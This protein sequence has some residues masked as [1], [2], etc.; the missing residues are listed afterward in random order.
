MTWQVIYYL[1]PPGKNPVSKFID[2]CQKKQQ[3]KILRTLRY[4]KE[5]GPQTAIPH[6]KKLSGT[7]FWE[8]R[9]LGKDNI[10][11][12]YIT[13][14]EKTI[15]LLHGF[16]KKTRKTEQKELAICYQRYEEFKLTLDK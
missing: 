8:M 2:Y 4:L 1:S 15:I 13:S 9:I 5:Y 12:I 14:I 3:V 6:I 11:I 16:F 7:P 10:R